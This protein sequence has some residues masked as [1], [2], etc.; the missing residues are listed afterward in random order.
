[1]Y[2]LHG[3]NVFVTFSG[4]SGVSFYRIGDI[5][6][7]VRSAK[8]KFPLIWRWQM[9]IEWTVVICLQRSTYEY[10]DKGTC[11]ISGFCRYEDELCPILG[12]YAAYS[13]NSLMTFRDKVSVPSSRI[14]KFKTPSWISWPC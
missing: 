7:T 8:I 13:G 11:L 6:K 3:F 5:L 2:E 10:K 9:K 1:M 14:K 4:Y 12:Y